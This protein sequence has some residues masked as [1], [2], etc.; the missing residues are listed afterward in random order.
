ME[1]LRHLVKRIGERWAGS[2][3]ASMTAD[4]LMS[5]FS[6]L[7]LETEKQEFPF[8]GW[9]VEE[10]P[11]LDFLEPE[12]R[13]GSVALME[14]SGS[15]PAQGIAGYLKKADLAEIV[16]GFLEWPRYVLVDEDD[17]VRGYLVVH[18]GLAGWNAP[19]IP[20]MNPDPFFPYPMA[21]LA[22]KDHHLVQAWMREGER[23]RVRFS[24]RG[25]IESPLFGHN[26]S[27]TLRGSSEHT[28]VFCAHL[29]TAYG[30]P[31]ANNNAAGVQA[32][33]DLASRMTQHRG[34][35]L[36]Y[37]FLACDACEWGF[38][39]SRFFLQEARRHDRLGTILAG[40]NLDTIA[41]GDSFYF[42]AHPQPMRQRA[43]KVVRQLKLDQDFRRIEFLGALAGSDHYS[44]LQAGLPAVEILFWPCEVYKLPQDELDHVDERL[45]RLAEEIAWQLTTLFEE[46]EL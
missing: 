42:L 30:S 28:L 37:Q 14:Y 43:E 45:I 46:E 11:R 39:G 6:D 38:L 15:T 34:H 29:D 16:P 8:L 23:V 27:A 24:T 36:S 12:Q 22:E 18:I 41:S 33:Y 32:L 40:I 21:I 20:L 2:T 10:K 13:A 3:A 17:A 44:F 35:R 5:Q 1:I 9:R 25:R 31:G 7:G 4:F 26:V 19:P